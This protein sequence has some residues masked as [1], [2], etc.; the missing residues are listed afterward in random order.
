M[1]AIRKDDSQ[2][3]LEYV[4]SNNID[5]N[6]PLRVCM[7]KLIL[8]TINYDQQYVYMYVICTYVCLC[9]CVF[10]RVRVCVYCVC[11]VCVCTVCVYCLCICVCDWIC[12]SYP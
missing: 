5:V 9:L 1:N 10:V 4:T 3:L 8:C 11:T 12:K 6:V 2:A 7:Y